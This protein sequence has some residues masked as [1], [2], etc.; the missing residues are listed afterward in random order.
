[1]TGFSSEGDL[2]ISLGGASEIELNEIDAARIIM[3]LSG[4]SRVT[5]FIQADSIEIEVSSASQIRLEGSADYLA[6]KA[7]GAST[8]ELLD[9]ITQNADITLRSASKG[10][11]N[12]VKTLDARVNGASTLEYTGE[13]VIGTLDV[14]GASTFRKK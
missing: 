6:V 3:D 10:T 9:F 5:G 1:V 4:A 13:P 7:G 11:F 12:L 8:L 14:T 2:V